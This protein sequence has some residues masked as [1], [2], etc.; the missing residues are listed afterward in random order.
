[1]PL[2]QIEMLSGG[3]MRQ[4]ILLLFSLFIFLA[5]FAVI[6][7]SFRTSAVQI[8][9]VVGG[10]LFFLTSLVLLWKDL[11]SAVGRKVF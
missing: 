11:A 9:G 4:L 6:Y 3:I 8:R 5:S 2:S 1:L 7:V 10:G